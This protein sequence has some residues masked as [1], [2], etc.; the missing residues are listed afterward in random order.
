MQ[1]APGIIEFGR[2]E[3]D[4]RSFSE[5]FMTCPVMRQEFHESSHYFHF[6][7]YDCHFFMFDQKDK[8]LSSRIFTCPAAGVFFF[9]IL[10]FLLSEGL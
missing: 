10:G 9:T 4:F 2:L 6:L 8:L 3:P 1:I 5:F 7:I